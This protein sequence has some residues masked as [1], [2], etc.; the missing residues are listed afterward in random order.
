VAG[1]PT[2]ISVEYTLSFDLV[3]GDTVTLQLPGFTGPDL[4]SIATSTMLTCSIQTEFSLFRTNLENCAE[5]TFNL[6][7]ERICLEGGLCRP[8]WHGPKCESY[9]ND[10]DTCNAHRGLG[11]CNVFGACTCFPPNEGRFCNF[12]QQVPGEEDCGSL[13]PMARV[14]PEQHIS[15]TGGWS[16]SASSLI[17]TVSASSKRILVEGTRVHISMTTDGSAD[18]GISLSAACLPSSAGKILL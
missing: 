16:E 9:C 18:S 13:V 15:F 12:T 8:D 2:S 14:L 17:F 1:R 3:S 11:F 5:K 10:L 4:S 6:Q 7:G